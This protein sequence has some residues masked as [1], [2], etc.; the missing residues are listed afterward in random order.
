MFRGAATGQLRTTLVVQDQCFQM[1]PLLF[2]FQWDIKGMQMRQRGAILLAVTPYY[3]RFSGESSHLLGRVSSCEFRTEAAVPSCC[4]Q[5]EQLFL[6][7]ECVEDPC[8]KVRRTKEDRRIIHGAHVWY[9]PPNKP[10][11]QLEASK[12]ASPNSS[13][14]FF[15]ILFQSQ[16]NLF[17]HIDCHSKEHGF[18]H[19][20]P[21]LRQWGLLVPQNAPK[22]AISNRYC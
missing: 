11:H 18:L 10:I 20:L 2:H 22:M 4:F 14:R 13:S 21:Q 8:S 5:R 19:L 16:R 15:F 7:D 12:H 17:S 3:N 9:S 1:E 6:H